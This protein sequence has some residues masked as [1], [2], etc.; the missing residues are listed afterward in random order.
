MKQNRE[1]AWI[2]CVGILLSLPSGCDEPPPQSGYAFDEAGISRENL[3][4]YLERAVTMAEFLT[5]DPFC[6]DATDFFAIIIFF[7]L[8]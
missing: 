7:N 6:N 8:D 5:V 3:E 1:R 4:N 2:I